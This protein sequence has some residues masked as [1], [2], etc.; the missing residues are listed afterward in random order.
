MSSNVQKKILNILLP[1]LSQSEFFNYNLIPALNK[2]L[3]A[4][5]K[6][7]VQQLLCYGLGTFHDGVE[8][9]SR[10]QLALLILIYKNLKERNPSF[11]HVIEIFDP[12]FNQKD[13]VTLG[14]FED[15]KF[16]ISNTNEYCARRLND[17]SS[18]T[19][20]LVFM[21]HLDK[22]LYNNLLGAN[23]TVKELSCLTV[24]GNSFSEMIDHEIC[25]KTRSKLH[26]LNSLVSD[27]QKSNSR[28]GKNKKGCNKDEPSSNRGNSRA[29]VEIKID[30]NFEQENIFN[31]LSFHCFDIDWLE[32]NQS[33][34]LQEVQSDW[35]PQKS[36]NQIE[37]Q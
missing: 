28:S 20:V 21:P 31:S 34:I 25:S 19:C 4:L 15:P 13:I 8:K 16:K 2:F 30:D 7:Q 1:K 36:D 23:W 32:H 35:Q 5:G 3:H 26:Y 17:F 14:S 27:F 37:A 9:A 6:R 33:K 11:S 12:S 18:G 29:L 22:Y 10:Y 24:L